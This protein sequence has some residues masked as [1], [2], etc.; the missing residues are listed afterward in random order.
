MAFRVTIPQGQNH[1]SSAQQSRALFCGVRTWMGDQKRIEDFT[2]AEDILVVGQMRQ[3][4]QRMY[5]KN[6]DFDAR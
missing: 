2:V 1:V 6:R 5:G 3:N 4:L